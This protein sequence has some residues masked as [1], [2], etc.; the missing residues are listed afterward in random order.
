MIRKSLTILR[1]NNKGLS[2]ALGNVLAG[3]LGGNVA[4]A[5]STPFQEVAQRELWGK[6][7]CRSAPYEQLVNAWMIGDISTQFF[8]T[9][10]TKH[11]FDVRAAFHSRCNPFRWDNGICRHNFPAGVQSLTEFER[12]IEERYNSPPLEI[13]LELFNRGLID[14]EVADRGMRK[15]GY[16]AYGLRMALFRLA[17]SIPPPTDLITFAVREAFNPKLLEKFGYHNEFPE[18]MRTWMEKQGYW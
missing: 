3:W 18:Q 13:L 12:Y 4:N 8:Q 14:E 5:A 17:K 6:F 7:P 1:Q 15:L 16:T 9:W 11:G 2:M 10:G